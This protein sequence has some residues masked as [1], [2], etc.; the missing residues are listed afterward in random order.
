MPSTN[1]T[2][3][4][5]LWYDQPAKV[6]DEAL[7]IGNGRLGAMV[8][9]TTNTDRLW[10]NEDSVWYGGPQDR[11]NPSAKRALSKIRQL[12]D[13]GRVQEAERLV[14][15]SFT[16]MPESQR[17]YEPLGDVFIYFGHGIDPEGSEVMTAGLPEVSKEALKPEDDDQ[18]ENYRRQLDLTTGVVTVEYDFKGI[19][20]KRE[21][22]ASSAA[23]MVCVR[24]SSNVPGAVN[25]ALSINRGDD[26]D[27]NRRLNKT[28]DELVHIPKGLL[29]SAST[30]KGGINLSMG[31]VVG[32][33]GD[34]TLDEDGVDIT[35]SDA[36]AAVILICGETTF[37]HEDPADQVRDQLSEM[38]T[39]SWGDLFESHLEVFSS[40]YSRCAL[41][42]PGSGTMSSIPTDK[43]LAAV[44]N[45]ERDQGLVSLM[46]HYGRYLLISCSREGLPANLQGIWNKDAMPIWGSKYTININIQMN[47]WPAEAANLA[48]CHQPLFDHIQRLSKKGEAVA[49]DMYGCRG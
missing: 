34:G 9:G 30:G 33:E 2:E 31:A 12:L 13:D 7:P 28:L 8:R 27:V 47:Y 21:Y 11:V 43:R 46:F 41:V 49:R 35:V 4:H 48:E 32:L 17:H 42:L 45:G 14:S 40:L 22:F 1:T 44:Q 18:P 15:R 26:D 20:H 39:S 5:I 3:E 38:W 37:R 19:Q 16:A 25:F 29:L 6:W 10:M 36:D 23:N 24:V